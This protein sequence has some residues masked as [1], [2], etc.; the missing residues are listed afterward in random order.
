MAIPSNGVRRAARS[1]VGR[2]TSPRPRSGASSRIFDFRLMGARRRCP[3]TRDPHAQRSLR[4]GS[5]L[6]LEP[7]PVRPPLLVP[8]LLGRPASSAARAAV[9][10]CAG[11]IRRLSRAC[12]SRRSARIVPM[13]TD[14]A[15]ERTG[16]GGEPTEVSAAES[17]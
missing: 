17:R 14:A 10:R 2:M 4:R 8:Q 16:E 5:A 9:V 12:W 15:A 13:D 3:A 1:T 11:P 6:A 7:S